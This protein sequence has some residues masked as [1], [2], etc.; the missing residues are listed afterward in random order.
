ML[1][2]FV[3]CQLAVLGLLSGSCWLVS[4]ECGVSW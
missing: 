2:L 3:C 4:Q 1:A